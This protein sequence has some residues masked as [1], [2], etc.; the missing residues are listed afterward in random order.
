[1]QTDKLGTSAI[2]PRILPSPHTAGALPDKESTINPQL[3]ASISHLLL[4]AANSTCQLANTSRYFSQPV[5]LESGETHSSK[6]SIMGDATVKAVLEII[7]SHHFDT[8]RFRSTFK[9]E[10]DRKDMEQRNEEKFT[11]VIRFERR[12][13]Q[14][15]VGP[16]TEIAVD[17]KGNFIKV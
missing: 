14:K 17:Y 9:H 11:I 5:F 2:Q 1:M 6:A 16:L 3:T 4:D 15:Q 12:T 8:D 10:Y 13:S 7:R